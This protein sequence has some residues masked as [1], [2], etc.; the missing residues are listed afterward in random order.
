MWW[1]PEGGSTASERARNTGGRTFENDRRSQNMSRDKGEE[2]ALERHRHKFRRPI[3]SAVS[4]IIKANSKLD[5]GDKEETISKSKGGRMEQLEL[6][7]AAQSNVAA[8]IFENK[9][10]NNKKF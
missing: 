7:D 4:G 6:E 3:C 2:L 1:A 10:K 5:E 9:C 8:E